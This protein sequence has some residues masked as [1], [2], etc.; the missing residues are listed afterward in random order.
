MAVYQTSV[1]IIKPKR[2]RYQYTGKQND[3][4]EMEYIS[5]ILYKLS[6]KAYTMITV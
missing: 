1:E 2:E 3:V 6:Y 4:Q 5:N